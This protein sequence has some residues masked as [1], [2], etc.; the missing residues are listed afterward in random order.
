MQVAQ[1][2]TVPG[3]EEPRLSALHFGPG[4]RTLA[5][6][7]RAG[8]NA[9]SVSW[10]DLGRRAPAGSELGANLAEDDVTPPDPAVSA[11]HRFLARL[12]NEWGGVQH[13]AF[14]DRSAKGKSRRELTAWVYDDEGFNYQKF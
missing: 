7:W 10:W 14:I 9:I 11:D 1:F 2:P 4:S 12:E 6:V 13:L 5:A 8:M 3:G